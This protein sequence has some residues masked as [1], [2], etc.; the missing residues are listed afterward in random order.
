MNIND[1]Q[2]AMLGIQENKMISQEIVEA[3]VKEGLIKACS[4]HIEGLYPIKAV[5]AQTPQER[6]ENRVKREIKVRL[7]INEKGD[8]KLYHVR[9]V[10]DEEIKDP[11]INISLE[12]AKEI[13]KKAQV[14]DEVEVEIDIKDF[15]RSSVSLMKNVMN[16]QIKEANKSMVYETYIDKVDEL[17]MGKVQTVEDKFVLVDIGKTIALLPKSEQIPNETY[18]DKQDLKVIIKSVSKDSKSAQ[19][20]VSRNSANLVKRLFEASV[21]EIYDGTVE[22]KGIAREANERTKMAVY[23]NN[24]NV[25]PVAACIGTRGVRVNAVISEITQAGNPLSHENIDILEWS[26]NFVEYVKNVMKPANVIGVFP[27]L[28]DDNADEKKLTIVVEDNQ[29]SLAIGKKGINARLAVKLLNRK[30]D[31]KKQSDVEAEGIDWQNE[32]MLFQA[33]EE[34]KRR[35][36]E[37][38]KLNTLR[39]ELEAEKAAIE[40]EEAIVEVEEPI[41]EEVVAETVVEEVT[42]IEEEPVETVVEEAIPQQEEPVEET[43]IQQEEPEKAKEVVKRRKPNLEKLNSSEYV[44]KYEDLADRKA[45]ETKKNTSKKK[46]NTKE[47][48]S[49]EARKRQIEELKNKEYEIKPEYSEEELEAFDEAD[50]D[51]WYDDDI[52]YDD[53]DEFYDN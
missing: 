9:T 35:Q 3:A 27:T 36:V 52:D 48:E 31:I 51:H 41:V 24:A 1:L 19:V 40:A 38:N 23:S 30:L 4:K 11:A 6:K 37:V 22:I 43:P 26:P 39:A 18:F 46:K 33:R 5:K 20:V 13:N 12:D 7:D 42:P 21:T 50:D 10:S 16:Q 15:G 8:C 17:T 45:S 25:D 44:S 29:L 53:Y 47:D 34:A 14:G 2:D 49:E 32:T 28:G